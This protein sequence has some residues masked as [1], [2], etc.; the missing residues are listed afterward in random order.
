M[1]DWITQLG[2]SIPFSMTLALFL[3]ILV[4]CLCGAAVGVERSKR[5][6][7][8][9]IRTHCVVAC[10]TAVFMVLSK[11]SF[12]DLSL[13]A[14]G[15]PFAGDRGA[16]PARIAAQVV[17][18]LG[19]LG[20]G[21]IFKNGN[22]IK[23]LTTAAGL[24]ATAAIGMAVGSGM[25]LIGIFTTLILVVLQVLTH[26]FTIGNDAYFVS[27]LVV[28]AKKDENVQAWLV[29]QLGTAAQ[30]AGSSITRNEND[31]VTYHLTVRT[32]KNLE[33]TQVLA[34]VDGKENI[35][36]VSVSGE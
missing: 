33:F 5:F 18:G 14:L 20:A 24:W 8:A 7:E 30:I 15:T 9:G 4:A 25:Y 11:Y 17:S 2:G 27:K 35:M 32:I 12:A 22:S 3:R 23:G 13:D 28:T 1:T 36:S 21:V 29:E 31:T 19:F 26:K 16:D 6:K 10:A 34:L